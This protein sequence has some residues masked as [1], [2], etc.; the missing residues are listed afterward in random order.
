MRARNSARLCKFAEPEADSHHALPSKGP[1]PPCDG[2]RPPDTTAATQPASPTDREGNP[3]TSCSAFRL[4]LLD[5]HWP[6]A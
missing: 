3:F 4:L 1:L 5:L 2:Q 6:Q